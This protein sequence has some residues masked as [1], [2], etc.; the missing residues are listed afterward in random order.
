MLAW[1]HLSLFHAFADILPAPK[2]LINMVWKGFGESNIHNLSLFLSLTLFN[3]SMSLN[4]PRFSFFL[5]YG[6]ACLVN[7]TEKIAAKNRVIA[8]N[9]T[10]YR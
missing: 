5:C 4:V 7:R 1:S 2:L 9:G 6:F 10:L 3:P 8:V